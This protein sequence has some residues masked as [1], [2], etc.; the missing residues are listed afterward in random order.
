MSLSSLGAVAAAMAVLAAL[1]LP[2]SRG[3][4]AQPYAPS[5]EQSDGAATVGLKTT[6]PIHAV[7]LHAGPSGAA[8]VVGT[9]HPGMQVE[10]LAAV[11]P[12]WLQVRSTEGEGWAWSSYF[13]GGAG[14][15]AGAPSAVNQSMSTIGQSKSVSPAEITSP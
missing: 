13:P 3:A 12:G 9:L 6:T 11:S 5:A 15:F 1:P 14:A 7:S 4:V 8:P 2:F 10:V